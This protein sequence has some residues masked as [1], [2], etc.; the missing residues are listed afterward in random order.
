MKLP[1]S[2]LGDYVAPNLPVDDLKVR[3]NMSGTEVEAIERTGSRW[4]GLV[5]GRIRELHRHPNADRLQVTLVDIGRQAPATIVCGAN[6][7]APGQTVPV[8]LPGTTLGGQMITKR[9]VRGI[10]SEGMLCSPRELGISDEHEG[11]LILREGPAPGTPLGDVLGDTVLDLYVTPNRPDC[12]SVRGMAREVAA[13]SDQPLRLPEPSV[14]DSGPDIGELTSVTVE[15][16]DLC[17]RYAARLVRGVRVG[18]S[19]DWLRRRL[20]AAGVRSINNVVDVSNYVMLDYGQ[21]LHTFDFERLRGRRIIVRRAAEDEPIRTIDNVERRLTSA[22]LAICDAERPV[23]VAGVMGGLDTE[24]SE[25]TTDVLIESASFAP[26]SIRRTAQTLTLRSEA[27]MRFERGIDPAYV[28]P[29]LDRAARLLAEVAG[30]T[31]ARGVIDVYPRPEPP[32][33]LRLT[34]DAIEALLGVQYA[35]SV[36]E[37]ILTTLGYTLHPVGAG[38]WAVDVPSFRRDVT[39]VADLIEDV[40]RIQG[41]DSIAP[42]L[43]ST[44]PPPTRVNRW[45][46]FERQLRT[47]L[48]EAGLTETMSYPLTSQANLRRLLAA[49]RAQERSTSPE[50]TPPPEDGSPEA[51]LPSLRPCGLVTT[52][53]ESIT[54]RNPLSPEWACLRPTLLD[55]ILSTASSNARYLDE[56]VAIFEVGRV[57]LPGGRIDG[58]LSELPVER[59]VLAV[60]LAGA[61]LPPSWQEV[62]RPADF[63]DLKGALQAVLGRLAIPSVGWSAGRHPVFHHG[64]TAWLRIGDTTI[65][66][67]GEVHPTCTSAYDLTGRVLAA[68][69]D[70]EALALYTEDAPVVAPSRFPTVRLDVALVASREVPAA[71]V[72]RVVRQ[73]AGPLCRDVR[74]FDVYTGEQVEPGKRSLAYA[75]TLQAPDRTLTME[76]VNQT[77]ER[78]RAELSS[79]IGATLRAG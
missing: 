24:V 56:G 40:A 46:R 11:I 63:W 29:A 12:L 10:T 2:W 52:I 25:A 7:I 16:P 22:M 21:P 35:S 43:P 37:R 26:T 32:R 15:A 47:L 71:E 50:G 9:T 13:L 66:V 5:V 68:E 20:E 44:P 39:V 78:I 1:L 41:Y 19:P 4:E 49:D 64:R 33:Q 79:A 54:I 51:G 27:S 53:P 55:S 45:E 60:T 67:A 18:P 38:S 73:A 76:E 74:L 62:E 65:G 72:E 31:I 34:L 77:R 59:R 58:R 28:G 3:L 48:L 61:A 70:L 14:E 42:T 23:A 57:Y 75:L 6:N 36:V 30:G 8:V 17:P 69:I